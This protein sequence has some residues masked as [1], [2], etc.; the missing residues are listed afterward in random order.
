MTAPDPQPPA[1]PETDVSALREAL[2]ERDRLR[3]EWDRLSAARQSLSGTHDAITRNEKVIASYVTPA[4]LADLTAARERVREV[5][6]EREVLSEQ[7]EAAIEELEADVLAEEDRA[8]ENATLVHR[9]RA[10]AES[11]EAAHEA[12]RAGVE[13]LADDA[14]ENF[15]PR[16]GDAG[17]YASDLRALLADGGAR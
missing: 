9:E 15:T 13:A 7:Y 8:N 11:A 2:A 6:S 1:A 17:V 3:A 5:E 16:L 10:R 12:L 14:P 4:L